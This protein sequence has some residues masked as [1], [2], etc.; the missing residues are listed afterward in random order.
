VEVSLRADVEHKAAYSDWLGRTT[1]QMVCLRELPRMAK[2]EKERIKQTACEHQ[3]Q[4]AGTLN[5]EQCRSQ[6]DIIQYIVR[7][8]SFLY[9]C[10]KGKKRKAFVLVP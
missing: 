8:A 5:S 2:I 9:F 3:W 1:K 7:Y 10:R 4:V 6:I